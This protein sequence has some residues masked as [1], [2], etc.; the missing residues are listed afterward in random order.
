M[1]RNLFRF[2]LYISHLESPFLTIIFVYQANIRS[3]NAN[4]R[5]F[6]P[7]FFVLFILWFI[8][9]LTSSFLGLKNLNISKFFYLEMFQLEIFFLVYFTFVVVHIF[10][11]LYFYP[12]FNFLHCS[13]ECI[14]ETFCLTMCGVFDNKA[15]L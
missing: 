11:V 4:P 9:L 13:F 10:E 15:V 2:Q 3:P 12:F 5:C 8:L 7:D 1:F 6:V 14:Y